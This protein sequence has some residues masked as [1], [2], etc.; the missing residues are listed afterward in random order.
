MYS[1]MR[2][3]KTTKTFEF[4]T[5]PCGCCSENYSLYNG[6]DRQEA[7]DVWNPVPSSVTDEKI[8]DAFDLL[9]RNLENQLTEA[10]EARAIFMLRVQDG[11]KDLQ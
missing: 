2:Y 10:K 4:I 7:E 9:V 5:P 8:Q 1:S 3:D 11:P 6:M